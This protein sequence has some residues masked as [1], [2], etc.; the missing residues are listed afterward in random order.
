MLVAQGA[1]VVAEQ[2]G[3]TSAAGNSDLLLDLLLGHSQLMP[4]S[5]PSLKMWPVAASLDMGNS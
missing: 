4:F 3:V 5:Q 1:G 2:P